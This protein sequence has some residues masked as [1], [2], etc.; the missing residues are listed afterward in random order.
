[1]KILKYNLS[2]LFALCLFGCSHPLN[3]NSISLDSNDR[4]LNQMGK[5][6]LYQAKPFDGLVKETYAN[7]NPRSQAQYKDGM[8][9]GRSLSW[10]E[11]GT[12]E[13]ER[14]YEQGEKDGLHLGWWPNGKIRFEY[15][16]KAGL[17]HGTFK[18]WYENG[19]PLHVFGYHH[20][21]EVRALGWRDNGKTYIN[22]VVRNGKKYG[23]TNARLCYSLKDEQGIYQTSN[24]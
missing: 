8:L 4:Q 20:G 7:G 12:K 9:E 3:E 24:Q 22:F 11:D 2:L 23:L 18:E 13:S 21:N 10:Y 1:M 19:K 15:Q 16:F 17:Y 5:Y 6:L 14:Y